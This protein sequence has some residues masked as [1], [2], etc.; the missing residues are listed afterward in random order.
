METRCSKV[1]FPNYSKKKPAEDTPIPPLWG[2]RE[3]NVCFSRII[4]SRCCTW[5]NLRFHVDNFQHADQK[6]LTRLQA[7]D[8]DIE[9]TH[10]QPGSCRARPVNVDDSLE[11]IRGIRGLGG[12]KLPA[13]SYALLNLIKGLFFA[14]GEGS[15]IFVACFLHSSAQMCLYQTP[16]GARHLSPVVL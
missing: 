8:L 9:A 10:G 7:F 4:C 6:Q 11:D 13:A 2:T 5:W 12:E 3:K 14:I 15:R 16:A 1:I